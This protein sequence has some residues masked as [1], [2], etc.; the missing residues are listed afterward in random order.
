MHL[1][2]FLQWLILNIAICHEGFCL[3]D[4]TCITPNSTCMCTEDWE[5]DRCHVGKQGPQV[6][7]EHMIPGSSDTALCMDG[8]CQNGGTC[9]HPDINCTCPHG[10]EGDQCEI[11]VEMCM[12]FFMNYA[13]TLNFQ[14]SYM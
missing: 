13:I 10:W 7:M 3:N 9:L 14:C 1:A 6:V 12:H 5:G 11:G 4:G 8:F 2:I